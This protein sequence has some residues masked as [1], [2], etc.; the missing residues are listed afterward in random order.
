MSFKDKHAL[1]T[2]PKT[3]AALQAEAEALR[4]QLDDPGFYARDRTAFESVTAALAK[5]QRE[6]A[7]AEERWLELEIMR[8]ELTGAIEPVRP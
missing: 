7:V 4:A 1:D 5:L 6:I 2:L 8:E 3:I